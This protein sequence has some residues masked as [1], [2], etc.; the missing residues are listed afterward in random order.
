M[1][2][3]ART[4]RDRQPQLEESQMGDVQRK[5]CRRGIIIAA[6]VCVAIGLLLAFGFRSEWRRCEICGM[7]EYER[8]FCGIVIE[9]L[10]ERNYDEFGTAAKWQQEH[11]KPCR[12]RWKRC[13]RK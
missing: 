3:D 10:C 11:G 1:Q 2:P 4:R 5:R 6:T 12:H 7:Q 9:C 13:Q 8:S